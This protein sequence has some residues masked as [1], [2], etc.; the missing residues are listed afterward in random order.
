MQSESGQLFCGVSLGELPWRRMNGGGWSRLGGDLI[1]WGEFAPG[2]G[3]TL[4][5]IWG[6]EALFRRAAPAI[7][8]DVVRAPCVGDEGGAGAELDEAVE[9]VC[10]LQDLQRISAAP[11][12][13]F[14]WAMARSD[15][16]RIRPVN[17]SCVPVA[18][19]KH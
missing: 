3:Q 4:P 13:L 17:P 2:L 14:G 12:R 11:R 18:V 15:V 8:G 9:A 1:R 16:S 5:G 10:A 6:A 19:F 7:C